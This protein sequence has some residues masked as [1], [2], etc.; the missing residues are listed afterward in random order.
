MSEL[1]ISAPRSKGSTSMP[2]KA[3][4]GETRHLAAEVVFRRLSYDFP[5]N[6]VGP[7]TLLLI[8]FAE[9][10]ARDAGRRGDGHQQTP[11]QRGVVHGSF[12]S[13]RSGTTAWLAMSALVY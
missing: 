12:T 7:P 1:R 3:L 8:V 2:L 5:R 4:K 11:A 13:I 10:A 9:H 6:Q